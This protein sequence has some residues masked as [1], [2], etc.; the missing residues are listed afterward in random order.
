MARKPPPRTS[1]EATAFMYE[2]VISGPR[3]PGCR[4][5]VLA[6]IHP[7]PGKRGLC[8]ASLERSPPI[9]AQPHP[10]SRL[11]SYWQEKHHTCNV[12]RVVLD[13]KRRSF[14]EHALAGINPRCEGACTWETQGVWLH[15]HLN[16][17]QD[18]MLHWFTCLLLMQACRLSNSSRSSK[19]SLLHQAYPL[20][21][22]FSEYPDKQLAGPRFIPDRLLS[23][24]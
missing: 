5:R 10:S 14:S 2:S 12:L 13:W 3:S 9:R 1:A 23:N 7:E 11:C 6:A 19:L 16:E 21:Q 8:G 22:A 17:I 18:E 4:T 24:T 15:R 20:R